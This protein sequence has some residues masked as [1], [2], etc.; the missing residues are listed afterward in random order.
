MDYAVSNHKNLETKTFSGSIN[1]HSMITIIQVFESHK[2]CRDFNLSLLL[3]HQIKESRYT[4][5]RKHVALFK[6]LR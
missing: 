5:L 2:P 4:Y 1:V 3:H 6:Y